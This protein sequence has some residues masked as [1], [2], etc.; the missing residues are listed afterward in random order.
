MAR[1]IS[2]HMDQ[3]RFQF[4]KIKGG[5]TVVLFFKKLHYLLEKLQLDGVLQE[6]SHG[7]RP[8]GDKGFFAERDG[9]PLMR[10]KQESSFGEEAE[11]THG[12]MLT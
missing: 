10:K 4:R 8:V 7:G 11:G 9:L 5:A 6:L 12:E 1:R 2:W 3:Y